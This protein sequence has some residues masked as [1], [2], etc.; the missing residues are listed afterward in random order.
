MTYNPGK[1]DHCGRALKKREQ[2]YGLCQVC[3]E[4]V[5]VGLLSTLRK[6]IR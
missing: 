3:E 5:Q 4:A 1:C 2:L 6:T